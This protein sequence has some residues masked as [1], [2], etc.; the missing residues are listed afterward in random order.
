MNER[1][2]ELKMCRPWKVRHAWNEEK[3][4]P[5]DSKEFARGVGASRA[6]CAVSHR[7]YRPEKSAQCFPSL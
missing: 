7:R 6:T 1:S 2:V 5:K 4:T 3:R